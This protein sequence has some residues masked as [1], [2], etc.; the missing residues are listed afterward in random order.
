MK[1]TAI[2]WCDYTVNPVKGMCPVAC[3]YCYAR[4]MYQ[5][6]GWA[7]E[8]RFSEAAIDQMVEVPEGYRV[9]VGS[10]ME[11][12]GPWVPEEWMHKILGIV[13][14][15]PKVTYIFL[16]KRPENLA[17]W[18]PWPR[19]AWV[20][21]TVTGCGDWATR[22]PKLAEVDAP[23]RFVSLEPLLSHVC[24]TAKQL[25]DRKVGWLILGAQTP[26]SEATQPHPT[27]IRHIAKVADQA[28]IPV[29]LKDNLNWHQQRREWPK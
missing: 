16:T 27:W 8:V 29:F 12:F 6:F 3:S 26:P 24:L 13:R 14:A 25:R 17:R 28:G 19:N 5:R 10:T 1:A 9:F 11:L 21:T 22:T 18:N 23:V 7:P 15:R 20:G 4:R 2:E